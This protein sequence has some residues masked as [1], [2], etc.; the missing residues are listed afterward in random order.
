[1]NIATSGGSYNLLSTNGANITLA[2]DANSVALPDNAVLGT[3]QF[4]G[5]S[6]TIVIGRSIAIA[7]LTITGQANTLWIPLGLKLTISGKLA[8]LTV[9]QLYK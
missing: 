5:N 4:S 3:V 7:N 2:G 8:V 6:N 1:L 9:V